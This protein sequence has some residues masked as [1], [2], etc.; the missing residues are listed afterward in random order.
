LHLYRRDGGWQGVWVPLSGGLIT[1]QVLGSPLGAAYEWA[2]TRL[3]LMQTY[4]YLPEIVDLSGQVSPSGPVPGSLPGPGRTRIYL[5]LVYI[6]PQRSVRQSKGKV[7]T[8]SKQRSSWQS[9]V[10]GTYK[11]PGTGSFQ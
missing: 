5:P 4:L 8:S 3:V 9:A 2:D 7:L 1:A 11:V 10:P 6:T